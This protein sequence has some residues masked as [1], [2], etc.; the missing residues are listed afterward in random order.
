MFFYKFNCITKCFNF[1]CCF[2]LHLNVKFIFKNLRF[3]SKI[4]R[5]MDGS[6]FHPGP[7]IH[8]QDNWKRLANTTV[9]AELYTLRRIRKI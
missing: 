7:L 8:I 4:A 3:G 9:N 5:I 1:K 2:F 6:H